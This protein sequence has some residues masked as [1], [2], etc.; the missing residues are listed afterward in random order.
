MSNDVYGATVILMAVASPVTVSVSRHRVRTDHIRF[1]G[2]T[3][4]IRRT[5]EIL[6][7][8]ADR[9]RIQMTSMFTAAASRLSVRA[10]EFFRRGEKNESYASL[11]I[12]TDRTSELTRQ[13]TTM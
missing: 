11:R 10:F 5:F 9:G 3:A 8:R 12:H 6:S 13:F 1:V 2:F 4:A 7:R